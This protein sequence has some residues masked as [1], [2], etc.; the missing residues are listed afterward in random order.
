MRLLHAD[1]LL[2]NANNTFDCRSNNLLFH[3][4]E[5]NDNGADNYKSTTT[6]RVRTI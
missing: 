6:C 1:E 4:A 3:D 2:C 5:V